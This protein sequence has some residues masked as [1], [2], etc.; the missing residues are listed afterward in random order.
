MRLE[1]ESFGPV[2]RA[3]RERR[4]ISLEQLAAET[5]VS[6]ELWTALE[7]NDFSRWPARLYARTFVR[8]Y[9]TRVGLDADNIVNEFCRLFPQ[10]D[11]RAE[12]LLREQAAI[13]GHEL[14]WRE[15]LP[16]PQPEGERRVGGASETKSE[17]RVFGKASTRALAAALDVSVVLT[18]STLAVLLSGGRL[19]PALA[20]VGLAYHAIGVL[21][22][23]RSAGAILSDWYVKSLRTA[24]AA[25]A[26]L[27]HVSGWWRTPRH[28]RSE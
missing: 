14:N 27:D 16:R 5:K 15:E 21:I 12:S 19:W 17:A 10:G 8:Q 25:A 3:V 6:V 22:M 13:I 28:A 18:V 24:P 2:L 9:A 20:V 7:E 4:G 1:K 23:G 26:R 11:R